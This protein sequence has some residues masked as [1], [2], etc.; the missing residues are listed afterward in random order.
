M[1]RMGVEVEKSR[2]ESCLLET[3]APGLRWDLI[4]LDVQNGPWWRRPRSIAR[5]LS[6]VHSVLQFFFWVYRGFD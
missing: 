2:G 1:S 5:H 3:V 6:V 4:A